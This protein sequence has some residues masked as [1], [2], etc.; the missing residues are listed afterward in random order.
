[1]LTTPPTFAAAAELFACVGRV[2]RQDFACTAHPLEA[3]TCG[4]S[5]SSP[6]FRTAYHSAVLVTAGA[7]THTVDGRTT[8]PLAAGSLH[9]TNPAHLKSFSLDADARGTLVTF[10]TEFLRAGTALELQ[11][12]FPFLFSVAMPAAHLPPRELGDLSAL[13]RGMT[14]AYASDLASRPAVLAAQLVALLHAAGEL[15][16]RFAG[17]GTREPGGA[18]ERF[19]RFRAALERNVAALTTRRTR[20]R[21]TVAALAAELFVSPDHLTRTVSAVSGL[22]PK[23]HLDARL[24]AEVRALLTQ[25][26]LPVGVIADRLGFRDASNFAR[27]TKRELGA[28]PSEVRAASHA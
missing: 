1:M 4:A 17:D 23:R 8:T 13:F 28:S 9:F 7:G 15:L 16:E 11:R 24:G 2:L 27:F 25:T 5:L 22:S 12:A 14:R 20:E 3:L 6:P 19:D 18:T 10:T 21:P 26:D